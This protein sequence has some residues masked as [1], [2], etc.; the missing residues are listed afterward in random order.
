MAKKSEYYNNKMV[1]YEQKKYIH[2]SIHFL[3]VLFCLKVFV[4][5]FLFLNAIFSRQ[6]VVFSE[7]KL[8]RSCLLFQQLDIFA[9]KVGTSWEKILCCIFSRNVYFLQKKVSMFLIK[10]KIF[11]ASWNITTIKSYVVDFSRQNLTIIQSYCL[12]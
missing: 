4:E 7:K 1:H 5:I 10:L 2:Q 6:K 3:Y 12:Y 9:F 8:K 11:N